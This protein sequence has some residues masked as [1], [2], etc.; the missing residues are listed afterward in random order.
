MSLHLFAADRRLAVTL[1]GVLLL[2]A[3]AL[4]VSRAVPALGQQSKETRAPVTTSLYVCTPS[5]FG[6]TARCYLKP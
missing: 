2:V 5:G 4:A 6:Q 3:A 1:L